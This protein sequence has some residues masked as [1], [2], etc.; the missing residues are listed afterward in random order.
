[1]II[2]KDI[3]ENARIAY[4][5]AKATYKTIELEFI[6]KNGNPSYEIGSLLIWCNNNYKIIDIT[7]SAKGT[8]IFYHCE[9]CEDSDETLRLTY[10]IELKRII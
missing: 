1:M 10:D 2:T 8:H 5:Y 7:A 9:S 6:K 4:E 3:L